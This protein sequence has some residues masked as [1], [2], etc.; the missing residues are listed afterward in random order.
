MKKII[1]YLIY[2]LSLFA[3]SK[4]N[5]EAIYY[6]AYDNIAKRILLN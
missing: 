1:I 3:C 4:N 2:L 5:D 6:N